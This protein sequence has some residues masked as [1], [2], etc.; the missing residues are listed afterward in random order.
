MRFGITRRG[1]LALSVLAA[2]TTKERKTQMAN[3]LPTRPNGHVAIPELFVRWN[4]MYHD[5]GARNLMGQMAIHASVCDDTTDCRAPSTVVHS[6][7]CTPDF[8]LWHRAFLYYHEQ[9]LSALG[10]TQV[11]LPYWDWTMDKTFP[12]AFDQ[13]QFDFHA[14]LARSPDVLDA[15]V[16]SSEHILAFVATYRSMK[17]ADASMGLFEDPV[18]TYP[19]AYFGWNHQNDLTTAAGDPVFYGHHANLDRLA[20]HIFENGWPAPT[21]FSYQFIGPDSKPIC[22]T[23][24]AFANLSSP[25]AGDTHMDTSQ[26]HVE[27]LDVRKRSLGAVDPIYSRVR[28]R[29]HFSNPLKMGSYQTFSGKGTKL[30]KIVSLHHHGTSDFVLWLSLENYRKAVTEGVVTA[31]ELQAKITGAL[32]VSKNN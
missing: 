29:I 11:G 22:T 1:V 4:A 26:F 24:D 32:Q 9:I 8:V 10:G 5:S 30:G 7:H 27:N 31:D 14:S 25:Y 19:H 17:P 15:D 23:L 2:C 3:S 13:S 6:V 16:F 28:M 12:A 18:H 20:T 21:G